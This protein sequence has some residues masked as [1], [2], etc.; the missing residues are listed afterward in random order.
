MTKTTPIFKS[1]RGREIILDAYEKILRQWPVPYHEHSISTRHGETFVLT[2][3]SEADPP[4]VLLH[5]STSN[6]AMWI[7]DAAVYSTDYHVLAVDVPGEPGKSQPLRFDLNGP[8]GA[9]WLED[10]LAAFGFEKATLVGISLGGW[11]ALK[12]AVTHPK[13]VEKLVLLCPGGVAPSKDL[14]MLKMIPFLLL[15][16]WGTGQIARM[17]NGGQPFAEETIRYMGVINTHFNPR[18]KGGPLFAD[19]ELKDLT[20]PVLLIAGLKD[21]LL[22]MP[23]TAA[24]LRK[25]LPCLTVDMLPEA[26]HVLANT[27][28]R[29][30]PF[31]TGTY[32]QE[33]LTIRSGG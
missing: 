8:A 31:L 25:L 1:A 24:R 13:R 30:L 4:L 29:A 12:F 33:N 27:A 9:E 5:G 18:T 17:M 26:G 23:R 2:C 14:F 11:M 19:D 16:E 15:G 32:N 7:G 21:P 10:V 28:G 3:G 20:M 6:S 22:D